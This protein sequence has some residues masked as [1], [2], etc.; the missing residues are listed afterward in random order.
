MISFITR[1][2]RYEE[3]YNTVREDEYWD[4]HI[5]QV[6]Q[7]CPHCEC[8]GL[9]HDTRLDVLTCNHCGCEIDNDGGF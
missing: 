9:S 6:D 1:N 5:E 4:A 2:D 8:Y 3:E 7:A